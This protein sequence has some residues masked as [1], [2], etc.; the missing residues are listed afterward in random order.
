V[1][2]QE[3]INSGP[4]FAK[5]EFPFKCPEFLHCL[6]MRSQPKKDF[7]VPH[8]FRSFNC[9]CRKE[10]YKAFEKAACLGTE[11]EISIEA[12]FSGKPKSETIKAG[13]ELGVP[14]ELTWSCY[15][16]GPLH[17]GKCESCVNRKKAFAQAGIRD[18][19]EYD[20]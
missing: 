12:P 8:P 4:L 17:C 11:K 15:R 18:P 7:A 3:V 6:P 14:F 16:D 1:A 13:A 2:L 20:E 19:T 10:F 5:Q 9:P